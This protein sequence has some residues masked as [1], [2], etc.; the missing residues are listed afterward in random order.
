MEPPCFQ[1]WGGVGSVFVFCSLACQANAVET[2]GHHG[3]S[4]SEFSCGVA[5]KCVVFEDLDGSVCVCVCKEEDRLDV[6]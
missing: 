5:M 1:T 6:D 4:W 2:S 3:H